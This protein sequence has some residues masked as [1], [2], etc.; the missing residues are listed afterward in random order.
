MEGPSSTSYGEAA[1][2]PP[3]SRPQQQLTGLIESPHGRRILSK[4]S[5]RH[6]LA[7]M[8]TRADLHR[9]SAASISSEYACIEAD[10]HCVCCVGSVM[11]GVLCM[12]SE[13]LFAR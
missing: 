5:P 1:P 6:A 12:C 3:P 7:A 2:L 13:T 9:G 11:S 10:R 4:V 8:W